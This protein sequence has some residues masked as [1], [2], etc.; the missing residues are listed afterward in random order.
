[1][2]QLLHKKIPQMYIH[3]QFVTDVMKPLKVEEIFDNEVWLCA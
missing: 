2:R 1:V 3:P